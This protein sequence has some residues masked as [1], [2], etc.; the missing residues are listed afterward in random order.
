MA[1]PTRGYASPVSSTS[2]V[3]APVLAGPGSRS[4][5]F[6]IDWH[7][8]VLLA[9]AWYVGAAQGLTGGLSLAGAS[10]ATVS[11]IVLPALAIYCLYHPLLEVLQHGSTPGKRMAG[12]RIV[13]SDGGA[14][15][16]AALLVR[17][18]LRLVDMLPVLYL[19]GLM[20]CMLTR[21]HVR[22]GDL[23][24]GTELVL[25]EPEAQA[26]APPSGEGEALLRQLLKRWDELERAE[27]DGIA[28]TLLE[29]LAGGS[30]T[31]LALLG[32]AALH[33]RL[34]QRL[35]ERAR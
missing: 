11:A 29:R 10:A 23:I 13:A 8:R 6:I 30:R 7:I 24:A 17:N 5:A 9:L 1:A 28:R 33:A 20:S 31:E 32:D 12:V 19:V 16:V 26:A 21:R 27:R 3:H 35:L 34:R 14:P 22:I 18:L 25:E 15:T 2:S 4:Y